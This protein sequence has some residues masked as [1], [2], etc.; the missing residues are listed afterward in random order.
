[1]KIVLDILCCFVLL[2][3]LVLVAIAMPAF[4]MTK[5]V[6]I[7]TGLVMSGGFFTGSALIGEKYLIRKSWSK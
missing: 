6:S 5:E 1:M 7:F 4:V 3:G 2:F